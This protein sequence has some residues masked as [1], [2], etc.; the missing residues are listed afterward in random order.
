MNSEVYRDTVCPY[1]VKWSKADWTALHST[2]GRLPKTYSKSN[3]GVF[4][5]KK[6]EY[7]AIAKSIS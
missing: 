7:S 2:N 5:G 4:E 3:P 6:V 1:S